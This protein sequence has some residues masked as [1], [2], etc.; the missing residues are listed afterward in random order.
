MHRSSCRVLQ[1]SL[2]PVIAVQFSVASQVIQGA[3]KVI[4]EL[5][6]YL[7]PGP[8]PSELDCSSTSHLGAPHVSATCIENVSKLFV[9]CKAAF[10]LSR[11]EQAQICLLGITDPAATS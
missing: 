1:L 4:M 3:K 2:L 7:R 6:S 10:E 9:A 8:E 5:Q 11:T